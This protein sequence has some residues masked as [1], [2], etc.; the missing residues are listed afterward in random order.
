MMNEMNR[1]F[2][3]PTTP[4]HG[5]V[6]WRSRAR[7]PNFAFATPKIIILKQMYDL[8]PDPTQDCG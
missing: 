7:R 8:Q 5:T 3:R 2:Q 4:T 1:I 6:A